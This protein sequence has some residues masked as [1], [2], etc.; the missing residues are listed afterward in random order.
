MSRVAD[1]RLTGF[2]LAGLLALV[3]PGFLLWPAVG[4]DVPLR[5]LPGWAAAVSVG[6]VALGIWHLVTAAFALEEDLE[7]VVGYFQAQDAAPLVLPFALFVGT[8]SVYRRLF[9][10]AYVVRKR[11]QARRSDRLRAEAAQKACYE[12][13]FQRTVPREP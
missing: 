10:P 13:A 11:W 8:R 5:A 7:L 9:A 1:L 3:L 12:D 2:V 6:C 4:G